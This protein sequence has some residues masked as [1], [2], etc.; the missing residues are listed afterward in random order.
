M[1]VQSGISKSSLIECLAILTQFDSFCNVK[2]RL[3]NLDRKYVHNT[4]SEEGA[5]HLKENLL[6]DQ[7]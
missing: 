5:G 2:P 3:R 7:E 4:L 1:G 6:R